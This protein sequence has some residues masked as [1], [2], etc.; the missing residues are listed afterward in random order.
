LN[1][2]RRRVGDEPQERSIGAI[3]RGWNID[4]LPFLAATAFSTPKRKKAQASHRLGWRSGPRHSQR[5]ALLVKPLPT[6]ASKRC[7]SIIATA[8]KIC[9]TG[10][11]TR[12]HTHASQLQYIKNIKTRR[13]LLLD[14]EINK[15]HSPRQP[16]ISRRLERDPFSESLYSTSELLHTPKRIPTS[17]ATV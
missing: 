10:R 13:V 11:S 17:M 16:R 8:T 2:F 1:R 7:T 12:V 15:I 4:Q 14:G 9:T 5:I 3:L 6:S